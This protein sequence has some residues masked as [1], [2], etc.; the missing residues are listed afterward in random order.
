MSQFPALIPSTRT[1]V[2]GD[3][4]SVQ[5]FSLSG[6]TG[7]FRRG[8]RRIG[9]V[10][11]LSFRQLTQAEL[12]LLTAHY[13]DRQGGFNT[14]F[15]SAEV[16]SGYAT[17]PVPLISDFAWR[18][19]STISVADSPCGRWDVEVEL[20]TV[21]IELGDL[22]FDAQQAPSSPLRLYV[23]DAGGAAATP[24]RDYIINPI[25]AA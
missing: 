24:A 22:I 1:Y 21:P 23:L 18:Y 2:P 15:L 17:P 4:P 7:A 16:W 12:A 8:N 9:Q 20:E 13:I 25:G 3:V 6:K 14:F 10:L 5:L 11:S 19:A